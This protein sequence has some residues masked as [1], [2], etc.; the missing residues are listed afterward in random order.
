M[1]MNAINF[2]NRL[3]ERPKS[4][5]TIKEAAHIIQKSLPYTRLYLHRLKSK[6]YLEEIE[7]GKYTL[8]AD[9]VET[10]AEMVIPSYI[11]FLSAYA[12]Y[13]FTTQIVVQTQIVTL[14]PKR[15]IKTEMLNFKFI[16]F[17]QKRFFGYTKQRFREKYISIAEKE[18]AIVDS[19]YLPQYCSLDESARALQDKELDIK[20][21]IHYALRMDSIITLKRLGYLLELDGIDIYPKIKSKLNQRYD[22]F[23]PFLPRLKK[24]SQKWKLH[25]NEVFDNDAQI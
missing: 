18:K 1:F 3:R 15:Q 17:P 6:R 4:V 23:N 16:T 14:K 21:I 11:S 12:I 8:F 5:L 2:L 20:K 19:L 22:L 7:P 25:I 24:K 10:A 9:S 13:G